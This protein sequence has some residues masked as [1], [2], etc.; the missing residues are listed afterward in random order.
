LATDYNQPD[1]LAGF[2]SFDR[3]F[4]RSGDFSWGNLER[5]LHNDTVLVESGSSWLG[6][7]GRYAGF[8]W[9]FDTLDRSLA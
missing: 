8:D 6:L 7:S 1:P 2:A 9:N 4:G 3:N 5:S